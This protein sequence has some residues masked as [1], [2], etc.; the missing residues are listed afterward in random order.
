MKIVIL[1]D[2]QNAVRGL[3]CF[4]RLEG[5]DVA[6]HN[7]MAPNQDALIARLMEAEAV[8]LIRERTVIHGALLERLPNLRLIS[9]T[10]KI[11][12]HIDIEACTAHGVSVAEGV[13][14]P[15]AP[16]ELCWAL[17]M[18]AERRIPQYCS[19]LK[20]GRWQ[21]ARGVGIGR[22]LRGHT[23]GIWGYGKI[24]RLVA[25]FGRAFG[26]KIVVW[27][28]NASLSAAAADGF[29]ALRDKRSL[30]EG[31]DVLSLHLRLNDTTQGC[32]TLEDLRA[33]KS[34]ALFVNTSRAELVEPGA[35][36]SA[37]C[38]GRPGFA[39]IDVYENEPVTDPNH[40]LLLM[41]NVI[42][43]PH[44]GYV[45]QAGYELYFDKAFENVVAF[46]A[47]SPQNIA[48]PTAMR[49]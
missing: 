24:G 18:A 3:D 9:Q 25:G 26:M 8:V 46:A 30:F 15:L 49:D 28:R 45:E 44:L 37:L 13:G 16:A 35:L 17:I 2:Y 23:L 41:D 48:N 12:N 40:P 29:E 14:S 33:M 36:R 34:D 5:H 4:S 32:V 6:V 43:T 21:S 22:A 7:D 27:G 31:S 10:G 19:E 20:E 47:G 38:S 39:A 42:C 11:S 1:D